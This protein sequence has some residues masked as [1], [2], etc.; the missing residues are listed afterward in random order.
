MNAV[1][2]NTASNT[3]TIPTIGPD[4]SCIDLIAASLGVNLPV[5]K[6]RTVFSTTTMASS[7]TI[8]MAN[9]SPNSVRVF[10][11]KPSRLITA[12]VPISDT[13]MTNVGTRAARQFCK[14]S[15]ITNSTSTKA[16]IRV[17][18]TSFTDSFTNVV[19]SSVMFQSTLAGKYLDSSSIL[20]LQRSATASA[21][22]PGDWYIPIEATGLPCSWAM[23]E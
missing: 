17:L 10:S 13:G 21:L 9:I 7:T 14:N 20:A 1:G 15:I 11:E 19:V 23:V 3:S 16:S 22:L 12:N 6:W 5:S 2:I 18:Y 4:T 8:P